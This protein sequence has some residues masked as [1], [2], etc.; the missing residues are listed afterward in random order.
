[1]YPAGRQAIIIKTCQSLA[2]Q[3][4]FK[5]PRLKL[6][7]EGCV[8]G[9]VNRGFIGCHGYFPE[10]SGR[11]CSG[12]NSLRSSCK[13]IPKCSDTRKQSTSGSVFLPFFRFVAHPFVFPRN[14]ANSFVLM[15]F[16][17]SKIYQMVGF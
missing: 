1:M 9:W 5:C 3:A 8:Y 17:M 15:S 12:G 2:E 13:G 16:I 10:V 14:R 7:I 4:R 6:F 11:I